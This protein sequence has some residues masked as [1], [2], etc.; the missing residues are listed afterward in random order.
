MDVVVE[1]NYIAVAEELLG[2]TVLDASDVRALDTVFVY[3]AS[4]GGSCTQVT[5]D[6]LHSYLCVFPRDN[7]YYSVFDFTR[8]SQME[9]EIAIGLNFSGP[10]GE[11]AVTSVPDTILFWGTDLTSSDNFF[12]ASRFVR[13]SDTSAWDFHDFSQSFIPTHGRVHGFDIRADGIAAIAIEQQGLQL[14]R[15]QPFERLG[16]VDTPGLAYDCAWYGDYVVVADQVQVVIVDASDLMNP[17]V[18]A[19]MRIPNA[20]RMRGVAMDGHFACVMDIYDGVY[21]VDVSSPEAPVFAQEIGLFDPTSIAA[22]NG[23]LYVTDE[24]NGLLI[25]TR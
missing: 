13:A 23:R 4:P 25:Y 3:T 24:G 8:G 17:R 1:G 21:V 19:Q 15:L 14:H 7:L 12:T 10:L 5:L 20:D 9:A 16:S 11:L 18:V 6:L 2:A 22:G